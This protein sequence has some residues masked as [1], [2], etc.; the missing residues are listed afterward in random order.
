M[1]T[2]PH[3]GAVLVGLDDT[4][5]AWLAADWA[6]REAELRGAVLRIVHAV[7]VV[8]AEA[9]TEGRG[10]T[11]ARVLDA[12]AGVLDDA[13]ARTAAAHP[14]L[15]TDAVLGHGPPAE[16]I[17]DASR[18]AG[19]IVVGTRGR[20]GFTGLLLGSVSLKTA[21]HADRPVVVVRGHTERAAHGDVVVGVRDERDEDAVRFG[22]AEAALRRTAVRLVHA[23]AP[24]TRAGMMVPQVS[25]F[26]AEQRLHRRLLEHAARPAAEYPQVHTETVLA[27]GTAAGALVEASEG[28]ALIVVP[29]HP[30]AERLGMR[31]GG[32]VHAVLHH[33]SCP[34]A[35]VPA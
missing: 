2:D 7:P 30:P 9:A 35:I 10:E 23:W 21:A 8:P 5:H 11:G 3:P 26:D 14:G 25:Q 29:R 27:V 32:V 19:L 22:L 13:R 18:D 4:L 17:L 31:L 34:V 12:A 33:A 20:G 16:V 15:P 6:A 24:L 28:A 1:T